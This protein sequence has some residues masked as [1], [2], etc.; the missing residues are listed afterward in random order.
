VSY[1]H[2][3]IDQAVLAL[4]PQEPSIEGLWRRRDRKRRNQ[5]LAA[6]AVGLALGIAVMA[7]GAAFLRAAG[8]SETGTWPPPSITT[9]PIVQPGEVLEDPYPRD[10]PTYI[11]AVDVATG[12][13]RTVAGC[14]DGCRLLTPFDASAD[15]GWIAYHLANCEEGEC[16]P[17]DP[18]GGLWVVGADGSPRSVAPGFNDAPWVWSPTGAQLAY[19]DVD[20]L[21]LLDPATREHTRIAI[22]A[23]PIRTI[24]WGPDG[25]S[26]AYS[27]EPPFIG[28]SDPGAFGV[29]VVRSGG[30]PE[31][32][33][34]AAGVES[35]AWSP[36]GLSLLLDRVTS[37]RSVIE[38]VPTDGSGARV[39]VE[40]PKSEGPGAPVWSP[41]G[42]RVA[43]IR[44]PRR[45]ESYGL[46]YWVIGA[47]GRGEVLLSDGTIGPYLGDGN[48]P[49][50]S[51]DSRLVA[52][53]A[54][55][56]DRWLATDA[57]GRGSPQPIAR[58][59]AERWRQV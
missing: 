58:Q 8:E 37:D 43:F 29:I 25:R 30:E 36:D 28:A 1:E 32:V 39:L 11:V 10:N 20:E 4:A 18:Q 56:G 42:S 44:T 2:D 7:L 23:G 12:A 6:G 15:G 46:E 26:I 13:R 54:L 3:L 17:S 38:V 53:S 57:D 34:Y 5:R 45:G 48:S 50:W 52:W 49:V 55:L 40:G 9:T 21:I 19:A 41:D 24:A 14:K 35:I 22:A 27:V 47:D 16:G 31:S 33:S 59:E 51:P